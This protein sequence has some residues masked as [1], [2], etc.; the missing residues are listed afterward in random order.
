MDQAL[1]GPLD[2]V[3]H[4]LYLLIVGGAGWLA[5]ASTD[6]SARAAI[7]VQTALTGF[8]VGQLVLVVLGVLSVTTE[9]ASGSVLAS[10][11]AVPRR[12]RLLVAK[13]SSSRPGACCSAPSSRSV[14][15]LAARTLTAVPGGVQPTDPEVLR[16]LGLQVAAAGLV[17]VLSVALGAVLR[18]TAGAVGL[19]TALVFVLPPALALAGGAVASRVS[20]GLPAL[21]VGEDAFLAVGTPWPVGMGVSARLGGR[22][23]DA[24]R[25]CSWSAGTSSRE[26]RG[27]SRR[28][29]GRWPGAA[30]RG[31]AGRQAGT[32]GR[33]AGRRRGSR[34]RR[35]RSGASRTRKHSS[36]L[37]G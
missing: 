9:F 15:A 23:L 1:V 13:T 19:G 22:H 24:R 29:T 20:Q 34:R 5:A 3:V 26:R 37:S 6:S 36:P 7:A 8:G 14:C 2:L 32:R 31:R 18:S 4:R 21:R 10:L 28:R 16:I 17:G 33:R 35:R 27:G 12:T 25:R 30:A 11:T